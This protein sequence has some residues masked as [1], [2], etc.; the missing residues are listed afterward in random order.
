MHLHPHKNSQEFGIPIALHGDEV[1]TVGCGKSWAK[2]SHCVSWSSLLARGRVDNKYHIIF[3]V[4]D[5]LCKGTYGRETLDEIW[6]T[7]IWSLNALHEGVWPRKDVNDKPITSGPF[8]AK[9]GHFL[10]DG[11]HCTW[12]VLQVD[13][14]YM[15][16]GFI[17]AKYNTAAEPCNCCSTN[18]TTKHWGDCRPHAAQWLNHLWSKQSYAFCH[19]DRH[20]IF[21]DVPSGGIL[22]YIPDNLHV[23][24]LGTDPPFYGSAVHLLTHHTMP[25]DPAE[26]LKII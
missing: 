7:V 24:H 6:R 16:K 1:A 19:P 14:D 17:A 8:Y 11:Y 2:M 5:C 21:R 13:L 26:N 23:K 12:W 3:Q 15:M 9:A 25:M 20:A 10:A 22:T 18:A 4:Y